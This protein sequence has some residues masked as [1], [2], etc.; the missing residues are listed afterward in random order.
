MEL[1]LLS[2]VADL[3]LRIG[4]WI[5]LEDNGGKGAEKNRV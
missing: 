3:D 1:K 2:L 4:F 5:L